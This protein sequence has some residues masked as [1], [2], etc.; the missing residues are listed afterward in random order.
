VEGRRPVNVVPEVVLARPGHLHR[1]PCA[2]RAPDGLGHVVLGEPPPEAAAHEGG[3]D[4]DL[5]GAETGD[6]T[7]DLLG[8]AG[9]LRR[10][11]D[12]APGRS[13]V[14]GRVLRLQRGVGEERGLVARLDR[15][16][17]PGQ[18]LRG[19][20]IAAESRP[21]FGPSSQ[22][23]P[24]A[25]APFRADQVSRA[26]TATPDGI[27]MTST[28]PGIAFTGGASNDFTV[29]PG[30]GQRTM[31]ATSIPGSRTSIPNTPLPSTLGRGS[32]RGSGLPMIRN[33]SLRIR[34]R[35]G[36]PDR[37][38]SSASSP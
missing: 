11:P 8:D 20:A 33:P 14:R 5:V 30:T 9:P 36:T 38:A 24:R 32:T 18:R 26:S 28:I 29:P 25:S 3:V 31:A 17:G 27:R 15:V 19:V 22:V 1:L 16:G 12:L 6:L 13:D 37:A 35:R 21:A 4:D 23:T 10:G 7:R 2:L 34:G